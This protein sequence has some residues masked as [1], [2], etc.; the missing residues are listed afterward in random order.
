MPQDCIAVLDVGKTLAK[1]SL[2]SPDMQ[3][4]ERRTR[5]N[6]SGTAGGY[7]CLDGG[8][9]A[10][11]LEEALK[12][13]ARKG[14]IAAIVPVAHGAACAIVDE[15]GLCLAPLDYEAEPPPEIRERYL[16]LRDPFRL[17]GSPSLAAG[18]NLGTQLFWLDT[19]APEKAR[20]GTIVTWPQYWAW[21]LS[22]VAATEV[23]SLGCHT[24]L[25]LP[26]EGRPSP[27]A[28]SQG[29][30]ARFAPLHRAADMLGRITPEWRRRCGLPEDCKVVCGIHDSNA[31]L[32]A[33][34]LYPEVGNRE[35][36]VLSTG[37]W[38]VAMRSV[39]PGTKPDLASLAEDRDCLVNVDAFGSPVPSSRFMGG[40]EVELIVQ[41]DHVDPSAHA[42]ALLSLAA[43]LVE[44]RV[45]ALPSFQKGVGPYP[46][47][48]GGWK[49]GRPD[50]AMERRAAAGLYLALMANTALGLIGSRERLVVEGRFA[51]DPLFTRA[52][53]S[54][55]PEQAVYISEM[56]DTLPLGAMRLVDPGAVP[57]ASLERVSPL[58]FDLREYAEEWR[59][60]AESGSPRSS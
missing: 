13:L 29:W 14:R 53:A 16:K 19:I 39:A 50:D 47:R 56:Q 42:G 38:F 7:P 20:R 54:L 26:A 10:A 18:L 36:T 37:T 8:G 46:Q 4:I 3:Q 28:V 43:G 35:L 5:P 1:L 22:G 51:G 6:A 33:A 9:I 27:L 25:W 45:F 21:L 11:W 57:H 40:R 41:A 44:K 55:R 60:L 24:D 49:G 2:W 30:A 52:L 32:L 15:N 31:D 17:T 59:A 12:D 48:T 58:D 23:T 34:R